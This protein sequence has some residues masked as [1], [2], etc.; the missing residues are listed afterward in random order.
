MLS[1]KRHHT[2]LVIVLILFVAAWA[3]W[4]MYLLPQSEAP[5]KGVSL[6]LRITGPSV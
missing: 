2:L 4:T 3:I 6:G 1:W 5:Q